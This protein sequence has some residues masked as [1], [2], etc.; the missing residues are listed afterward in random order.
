[1]EASTLM[2]AHDLTDAAIAEFVAQLPAGHFAV[3]YCTTDGGLTVAEP[4]NG[5][6]GHEISD[7]YASDELDQLLG[8]RPVVTDQLLTELWLAETYEP[9]ARDQLTEQ[10]Y[11][12]RLW[13]E[14]G[15]RSHRLRQG[16]N[17][18]QPKR[19]PTKRHTQRLAVAA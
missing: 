2:K 16:R 3:W 4:G 10:E 19:R 11:R 18:S 6:Y 13:D 5:C 14:E 17:W 8:D 7:R 15:L 1:M 12:Q 9:V